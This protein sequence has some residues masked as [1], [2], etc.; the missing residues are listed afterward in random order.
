M[1]GKPSSA[2]SIPWYTGGAT[3]SAPGYHGPGRGAGNS[4]NALLDG[5]RLTGDRKFPSRRL[6]RGQKGNSPRSKQ[7][8]ENLQLDN[9]EQRWFYTMFLQSLGTYLARRRP[10]AAN[11]T[12][13]TC[14]RGA[15]LL[16]YADWMVKHEY[17]YLDRPE[18]VQFPTETWPAQELRKV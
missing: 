14:T 5:Y 10:S 7:L 15:S 13:C 4:L 2:G 8:E 17:P 6:I 11:W 9:P 12:T 3:Q 18:K 16:H 1:A